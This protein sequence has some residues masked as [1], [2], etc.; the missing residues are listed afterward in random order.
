[1]KTSLRVRVLV[2]TCLVVA[3]ALTV[4]GAAGT[5]LFRHYLIGRTDT[6]LQTFAS[7]TDRFRTLPAHPPPQPR[8][9]RPSPA[10]PSA[11]IIEVVATNGHIE[12]VVQAGLHGQIEDPL[13]QVP[14]ADLKAISKPFTVVSGGHSWRAIVV[15]RPDKRYTVVAVSLDSVLPEIGRA[16]V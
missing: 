3:A 8:E 16:H 6:Q 11:Y 2:A 9:Y 15:P 10:L 7:N 4:M 5:V 1:M 13:P 14:T 12:R